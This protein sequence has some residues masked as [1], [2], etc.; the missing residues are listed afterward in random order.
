MLIVTGPLLS[1]RCC[2]LTKNLRRTV[3]PSSQS[4]PAAGSGSR[5]ASREAGLGLDGLLSK[6]SQY[7]YRTGLP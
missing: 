4:A 7:R 2:L 6:R 3:R 1:D 5:F